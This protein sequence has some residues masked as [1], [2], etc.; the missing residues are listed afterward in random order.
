MAK[1]PTVVYPEDPEVR[2]NLAKLLTAAVADTD[3]KELYE[4]FRAK[5][6]LNDQRIRQY[7]RVAN[8]G[9]PAS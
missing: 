3:E 4:D 7:A 5:I 2:A 6:R 9:R 8:G 1:Q